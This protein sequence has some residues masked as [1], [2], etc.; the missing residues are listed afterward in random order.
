VDIENFLKNNNLTAQKNIEFFKEAFTH[1]SYGK[2]HN[3]RLEFLG[4]AVLELV[5]TEL[6]FDQYKD[7]SEG[8]LTSFRAALVR[9]QSLSDEALRLNLGDLIRMSKGEEMTG[10]R[11]RQYI[12]ADVFEALIGAIYLDRGYETAKKFIRDNLYYKI[13]EIV[14]S[15]SDIDS[16]SKLQEL[17]QEKFKETPYYK[18]IKEEG[19]DHDKT[20]T[21][22]VVIGEK[23]YSLG[24]GKSKQTA[25]QEAAAKTLENLEEENVLNMN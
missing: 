12:L 15:R 4:D 16:K 8:E 11:A 19:P 3:E 7:M 17:S 23:E 18:V 21:V 10:G 9:T 24:E 25:E 1:R 14:K 2:D 6:L 5:V 20:F 13:N 22:V